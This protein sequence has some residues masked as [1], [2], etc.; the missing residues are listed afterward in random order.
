MLG[1]GSR[2]FAE[3]EDAVYL[4]F[5]ALFVTEDHILVRDLDP[6]IVALPQLGLEVVH[7]SSIEYK[8][9]VP[10]LPVITLFEHVDE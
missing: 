3:D 7:S 2:T 6:C 10:V 4:L 9:A 5:V 1:G 8:C